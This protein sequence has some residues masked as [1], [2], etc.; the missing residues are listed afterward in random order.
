MTREEAKKQ[1]ESILPEYEM[2]AKYNGKEDY[3]TWCALEY[4]IKE[5]GNETA[6]TIRFQKNGRY[7]GPL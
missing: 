2:R 1:L 3:W 4:A 5:L 7:Q 6:D